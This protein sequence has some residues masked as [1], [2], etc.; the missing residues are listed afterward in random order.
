MERI[1]SRANES[2]SWV[3]I[4]MSNTLGTALGDFTAT[5]AGLGFQRG[6]LVFAALISLVGLAWSFSR[7]PRSVLFWAAY[8]PLRVLQ[9]RRERKIPS[10][11]LAQKGLYLAQC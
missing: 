5:D 3:T 7:I 2:F 11:P 9:I 4:L 8:V 10:K 6:A 1:V